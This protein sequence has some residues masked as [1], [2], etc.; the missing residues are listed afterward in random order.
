MMVTKAEEETEAA[1]I[2]EAETRQRGRRRRRRGGRGGGGEEADI[3]KWERDDTNKRA[4]EGSDDEE[5]KGER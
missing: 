5:S 2:E 3:E 1:E 4:R